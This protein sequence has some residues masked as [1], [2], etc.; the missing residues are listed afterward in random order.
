MAE[1]FAVGLEL[2]VDAAVALLHPA[3]VPG[4]VEVEEVPAV[5]L[6][7]EAFARGVRGDQDAER[8]FRRI[9]VEGRLDGLALVG[10]RGAVKDRDAVSRAVSVRD[11]RVELLVEI[12]LRVVVFGEDD[13]ARVVPGGARRRAGRGTCSPGSNR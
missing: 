2:A 10:G 11:H 5:R 7:V 9:C 1:D 6:E 4:D 8:V 12:A 13:H 3:R